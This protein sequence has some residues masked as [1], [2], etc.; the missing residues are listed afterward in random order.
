MNASDFSIIRVSEELQTLVVDAVI[1][2]LFQN[3]AQG[4][5]YGRIAAL[6]RIFYARVTDCTV[7]IGIEMRALVPATHW[8]L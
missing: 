1:N 7:S 5:V 2:V 8:T 4:P 3:V 6:S